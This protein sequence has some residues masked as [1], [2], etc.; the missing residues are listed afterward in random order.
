MKIVFLACISLLLLEF[1][2]FID[3][4]GAIRSVNGKWEIYNNKTHI[5]YNLGKVTQNNYAIRVEYVKPIKTIQWSSV[6]AHRRLT[7][8]GVVCGASVDTKYIE[9][10][11]IKDGHVIN[12]SDIKDTAYIWINVRGIQI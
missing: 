1:Y 9:I 6:T 12:P 8:L 7:V 10:T 11:C 3:F 4:G 2:T 5:S